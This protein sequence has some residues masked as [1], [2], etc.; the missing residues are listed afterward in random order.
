[1]FL[2]TAEVGFE[3]L[4]YIEKAWLWFQVVFGIGLMIFIHELGHFIAAKKIGVRV[5]AFSLGFGPRIFGFT[6]SGTEYRLSWIPL[7]GYVKMAGEEPDDTKTSA[8]DELQNRTATE[9]M[10]IFAAGVFM[11]FIF[12]FITIP[13]IFAVG[14]PF[15]KPEVG[16]V[17]PGGPAW[18]SGI[19]TGDTI[20]EVNGNMVYE[21]TDIP[22]NIA[23]GSGKNDQI[24]IER[25][26]KTFSVQVAP[27][28]NEKQGRYQIQ[29]LAPTRYRVSVE[30]NSAANISGLRDDDRII[31]MNGMSVD[32]WQKQDDGK[33]S[34]PINLKVEREGDEGL[35]VVEISFTPEEVVSED[36]YLIGIIQ[37]KNYVKALRGALALFDAGFVESDFILNVNGKEIF[38]DDDL[39]EAFSDEKNYPV[40]VEV[41]RSGERH[42]LVFALKWKDSLLNDLAVTSNSET[43]SVAILEGG[44]LDSLNKPFVKNGIKVL[45]VNGNMTK[46]FLDITS[47]VGEAET[48]DFELTVGLPTGDVQQINVTAKPMRGFPL[49]FNFLPDLQVRKLSMIDAVKA[50]V[51][52]SLY[53][54]KTCY[55]TLSKIL[56]GDVGSKNIGGIITI[57]QASYTF[58][59]L[60]L[61]RLFFFLAIL[62]INLGFLNILPIPIL[63]GGHLL[64]L[65]I[66]KIK[67]SPVNEKVLGYSQIIG[68]A[69]ILLL[70]IYVTWN[71]IL[72]L[73]N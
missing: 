66:E 40:T 20:L 72:R 12:A 67:G 31:S 22:L 69:M 14:V 23:L 17:I 21:F 27:E 62:S 64:F 34:K 52:C 15:I 18:R 32:E 3:I 35:S 73:I 36:K 71:D 54:I 24:L 50:G 47:Q 26:S 68:L 38:T 1:M 33:D 6:R 43:N 56:T 65:L 55:L 4:P 11:N 46:T 44:A 49:G 10:I 51:N 41:K 29:L 60:G 45:A 25:D 28:K 61:A 16:T 48:K 19:Q 57:G 30:R 5:E 58:A 70:L 13:I 9:R 42:K 7:G 37:R 59:K 53:M 8:K 2:A 63:D 39:S